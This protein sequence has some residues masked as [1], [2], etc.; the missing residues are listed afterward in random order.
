MKK[1]INI[2]LPVDLAIEIATYG[3]TG[4]ISRIAQRKFEKAVIDNGY[5]NELTQARDEKIKN[6]FGKIERTLGTDATKTIKDAVKTGEE[7]IRV[8]NRMNNQKN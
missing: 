1:T 8:A 3:E 7:A 6:L 2:E 4:K 5:K